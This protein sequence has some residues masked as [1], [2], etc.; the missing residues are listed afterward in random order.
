ML[1][2]SCCLD[3]I[4]CCER[5]AMT[6]ALPGLQTVEPRAVPEPALSPSSH[7]CLKDGG[8]AASMVEPVLLGLEVLL[9]DPPSRR[10]ILTG[11]AFPAKRAALGF[12]LRKRFQTCPTCLAWSLRTQQAGCLW[13]CKDCI[14]HSLFP[15]GCNTS[16]T[17]HSY[18][19]SVVSRGIW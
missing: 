8:T 6:P 17:S 5:K 19:S 11:K 9:N 1:G 18:T 10:H 16:C 14:L 4:V 7:I 3:V 15:A 2:E 13:W 12:D